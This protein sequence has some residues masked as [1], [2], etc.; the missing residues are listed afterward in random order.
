M[1]FWS[2][3][4]ITLPQTMLQMV[5]RCHEGFLT[6]GKHYM[7][8]WSHGTNGMGSSMLLNPEIFADRV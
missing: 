3:W 4:M 1:V 6:A 8:P 2:Q 7:F 5:S